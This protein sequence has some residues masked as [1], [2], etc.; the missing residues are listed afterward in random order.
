MEQGQHEL[1]DLFQQLGLPADAAAIEDFIN[2]HR[3]LP[4]TVKVSEAPFWNKSQRTLL[5]QA[6]KD[7]ADWAPWVDQLN[8][9]LH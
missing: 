5:S 1:S 6:I 7:D 8:T 2:A 9:R 3:P 4:D